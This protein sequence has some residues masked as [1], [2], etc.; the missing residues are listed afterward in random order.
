MTMGH[1]HSADIAWRDNRVIFLGMLD[2]ELLREYL[3]GPPVEMEV[4]DR[5]RCVGGEKELAV[6]GAERRDEILGTHAFG[7]GEAENTY[8]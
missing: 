6:F 8:F 1:A 5:D 4:H 3:Q 2:Q 7:A